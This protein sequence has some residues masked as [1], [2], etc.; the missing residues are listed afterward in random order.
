M[1]DYAT[2]KAAIQAVIYENGNQEI[3]GSVMQATL[4]A[5]VN[6]LGANYQY[7]GIA[8]PST[9]PGTPDQNVFYLA[10]TA[11]TYVNF[12]NI[13][14]AENEVAILKY[15][16]SWTK[17]VAG[18]ASAEKV[19]QLSKEIDVFDQY[20]DRK[21]YD[22]LTDP[23]VVTV[24][25]AYIRYSSGA[26]VAASTSTKIR[27]HKFYNRNYRTLRIKA[28]C[29]DAVPAIVAF[30]RGD[31]VNSASSITNATLLGKVQS[32]VGQSDYIVTVPEG[33][34]TIAI[35]NRYANIAEPKV[36]A[37]VD[38]AK[39]ELEDVLIFQ[40]DASE[41]TSSINE[42]PD[43]TA[44]PIGTKF[45]II[46]DTVAG[47][48]AHTFDL[49]FR[50]G[51]NNNINRTV[52]DLYA[53]KIIYF[54]KI[55]DLHH[56]RC[57]KASG[58]GNILNFRLY[59]IKDN[60]YPEHKHRLTGYLQS[61]LSDRN[62]I[63]LK[64]PFS[65]YYN[66]TDDTSIRVETSWV[67]WEK[68]YSSGYAIHVDTDFTTYILQINY[69]GDDSGRYA[70][71]QI[72]SAA[73]R[74]LGD[75]LYWNLQIRR[76]DRRAIT[77][78]EVANAV[79]VTKISGEKYLRP[80]DQNSMVAL[81]KEV[82]ELKGETVAN[83]GIAKAL[84]DD[85]P[86][87]YHFSP[88]GFLN[89]PSG[90]HII[91]SESLEDIKIAARLGFSFIEANVHK[92]ADNNFIVTHGDGGTF[93]AE[94]VS[95][96]DAIISPSTPIANATVA[97]IK[98]YLRFNSVID[99]YKTTIPTLEEFCICC[100][101][102]SIGVLAGTNDPD[103]I[104]ILKR[105]C[106]REVILYG[107]GADKRAIFNGY[108]LDWNNNSTYNLSTLMTTAKTKGAPY[109]L[110]VGPNLL[111]ALIQNEDLDELVSRF[112]EKDGYF[113][114]VAAVYQSESDVRYAF[115]HGFDFA[116]VGHEVNPFDDANY[117][118]IDIDGDVSQFETTGTI[119]NGVITLASG[120]TV[121]F[122]SE[123]VITL[124]KG[125]LSL[126]FNGT[127]NIDFGSKGYRSSISSDGTKDVIVSDYF[128]RRKT[129]CILTAGDATTIT[130]LVYKTSKC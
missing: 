36:W 121:A 9:N 120:Q 11:G 58:T 98:A 127:L 53:G 61:R 96:N 83:G 31:Y 78:D 42:Q 59:I 56:I 110:C 85:K 20:T 119:S 34:V 89:D 129:R 65:G 103:A 86:Y 29:G 43:M 55:D 32:V 2:L 14:L 111:A 45:K 125:E 62:T 23:D 74:Y 93:G 27:L 47:T 13:V 81:Q 97:D 40:R 21:E 79:T 91:A 57:Y 104:Q 117:E 100:R 109:L 73:D 116:G 115:E 12:G 24:Q 17:E 3:T 44:Y 70:Y 75:V 46:F 51:T 52:A 54:E 64:N 101:E 63:E 84:F 8:T 112:H 26:Q 6:S 76:I 28:Q 18:L 123:N 16:G 82:A 71:D 67:S 60:K 128:L 49:V 108:M 124:G 5:I 106:G 72:S 33:C 113:L 68:E 102:N 66:T 126:R 87:Y 25:N 90:N 41:T 10:G 107:A 30:Y 88:N 114:G 50:M 118:I 80:A 95:L 1:A 4:L 7:A 69:A 19:N 94:V 38:N 22:L 48:G 15:N 92:T 122:A 99:K 37:Y 39:E 105:I 77:P 130:N 35:S